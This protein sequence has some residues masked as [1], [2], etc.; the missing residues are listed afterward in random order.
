MNDDIRKILDS[1][2]YSCLLKLQAIC[3]EL[4]CEGQYEGGKIEAYINKLK[5]RGAIE[6]DISQSV[7]SI[8]QNILNARK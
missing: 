4:K 3:R 7:K 2:E 6:T 8:C 5:D 1:F